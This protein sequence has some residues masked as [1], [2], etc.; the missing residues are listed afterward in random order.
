MVVDLWFPLRG[1][2]LPSDHGYALFSA[3]SRQVPS[4]H[5]DP[6]WGVHT[7]RGRPGGRGMILLPR[8][9][10]LGVRVPFEVSA[11]LVALSGVS[12]DVGGHV[13]TLQPPTIAPLEPSADLS[14]RLV[15][16]RGYTEPETF[17][18]AVSQQLAAL[19]VEAE[20]QLGRR[21]VTRISERQIVGWAVRVVGLS[22]AASLRVQ[23]VGLGG[24]RHMGCG[25]FRPSTHALAEDSKPS[26]VAE[27]GA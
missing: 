20:V 15:T 3:L 4:L 16:I 5:E 9:A 27:T 17:R 14:A 26:P 6:R 2:S 25:L 7:V 8:G 21:L 19:G 22:P 23:E 13:V 18:G 24:R 1:A 11:P 12:L 10:R